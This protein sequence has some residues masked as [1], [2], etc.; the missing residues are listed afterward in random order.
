M[1]T[2]RAGQSAAQAG[3]AIAPA[4]A[5]AVSILQNCIVEASQNGIC[6]VKGTA[7]QNSR[8]AA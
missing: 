3:I 1:R 4:T 6:A 8:R 7:A 5:I 2:A